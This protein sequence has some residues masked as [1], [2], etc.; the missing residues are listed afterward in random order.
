V[1]VGEGLLP[2][3]DRTISSVFLGRIENG[4]Q[5]A[6]RTTA[7]WKSAVELFSMPVDSTAGKYPYSQSEYLAK[8]RTTKFGLC[9][10]GYGWK[11]NREIEYLALGVVPIITEGVD[12]KN[13][14]VPLVEGVHYFRAD[15]PAD[16]KAIVART[17]Q[18]EWERMSSAC[19]TWWRENASAE[20][21]FRLTWARIDQCRPFLGI[22]IPPWRGGIAAHH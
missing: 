8:L 12:I 14:L 3:K 6:R 7:D 21:L 10:P 20:G 9:L 5:N 16:V 18:A 2:W 13:Y 15:T 17:T 19:H 4:V 11:C 22:G 1:A